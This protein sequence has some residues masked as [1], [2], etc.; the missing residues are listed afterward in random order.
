MTGIQTCALPI[1]VVGDIVI[2]NTGEEIP[3]DGELLEAVMLNI[4]ESTL[5]GEPVCHKTTDPV[6]FDPDATFPSNKVMRGTKVMEGHGIMRVTAVG[7]HTENGKV[8]EAAQIDDSV[9][10]PLDEQ[11][12]RL[13]RLI[14]RISYCFAIAIVVGRT[15]MYFVNVDFEWLSFMADRKSVV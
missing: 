2:I 15:I 6:Q 5:T 14:S 12:E 9:K 4:D 1:L 10:T 13:G 7:D 3:A 8:F 11:F